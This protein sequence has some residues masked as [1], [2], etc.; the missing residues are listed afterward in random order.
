MYT[1]SCKAS[2]VYIKHCSSPNLPQHSEGSTYPK[3]CYNKQ[4]F[5][6]SVESEVEAIDIFQRRVC[7]TTDT[8]TGIVNIQPT[9]VQ[10]PT[11][12]PTGQHSIQWA[13]TTYWPQV[14]AQNH[15]SCQHYT[16]YHILNPISNE[17][18]KSLSPV[19][20]P[21]SGYCYIPKQIDIRPC[22]CVYI[23]RTIRYKILP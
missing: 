9:P 14:Q 1:V 17:V 5:Q 15:W 16:L 19:A 7:H 3:T 13:K 23:R 18:I 6:T 12:Q 2:Y 20:G 22:M 4:H 21:T 11:G 10:W 8:A